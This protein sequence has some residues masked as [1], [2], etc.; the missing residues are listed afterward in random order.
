MK[1]KICHFLAKFQIQN[2]MLFFCENFYIGQTVSFRIRLP[3]HKKA[4]SLN[5][6]DNSAVEMHCHSKLNLDDI[7]LEVI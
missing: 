2:E 4:S 6:S 7:C 1:I 5:Y 3:E